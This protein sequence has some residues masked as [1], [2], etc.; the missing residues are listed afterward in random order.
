MLAHVFAGGNEPATV[1][2]AWNGSGILIIRRKDVGIGLVPAVIEEDEFRF[3]AVFIG[4]CQKILN[5]I[6]KGLLLFQVNIE[7]QVNADAIDAINGGVVKFAIVDNRIIF[8]PLLGFI[9][10]LG[11]H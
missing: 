11:W 3:D 7:M 8:V 1:M 6:K 2:D 9:H 10:V 4:A 5:V